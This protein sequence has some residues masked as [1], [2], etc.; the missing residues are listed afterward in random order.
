MARGKHGTKT[1]N[2]K[3][4]KF[5]PDSAEDPLVGTRMVRAAPNRRSHDCAGSVM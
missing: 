3:E 2:A 4:V 5:A 1:S